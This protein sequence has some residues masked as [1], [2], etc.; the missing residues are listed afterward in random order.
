MTTI[1]I[2]PSASNHDAS[3][4]GTGAV[5]LTGHL[6]AT[7]G[8]HWL[9]LLLPGVTVPVGATI[10]SATLYYK[11]FSTT[12][13]DPGFNWYAEASDSASVF[14]TGASNVSGRSRTAAVTGDTATNIGTGS[15]RTVNITAQVDE[16]T[17]RTGW[18]SGNNIALIA[19]ATAAADIWILSYDSGSGIW[20]VEI[21]YTAGRLTRTVSASGDDG[22]ES[23]GGSM[24]L[25]TTTMDT[26]SVG[27][28]MG[29]MFRGVQVPTGSSITTAYLKVYTND[30][31]RDSP[32]VTIKAQYNPAAFGTGST[33]FSSRTMTT[34]SASWVAT[35]IGIGAYKNSPSLTSVLQEVVDNGGW[36]GAGDVAFF[37]IQNS[38]SGWLRVASWDH[39]TDPPPQ[40]YVEWSDAPSPISG[41]GDVTLGAVTG[42]AAAVLPGHG[43]AASTLGAVTTSGA[44]AL[45]THGAGA[46]TLGAVTG[47]AAG[48]L[49]IKGAAGAAVGS[50]SLDIAA[51]GDDGH[52]DA[53]GTVLL[54]ASVVIVNSFTPHAGLLFRNVNIPAG[55][56]VTAAY[57]NIVPNTYDDPNL[58]IWGEYDPASFAATSNNLSGRT[59]TTANV[60]WSAANIGLA[61]YHAS[62]DIS[63]VIQEIVDTV[64]WGS[65][66]NLALHLIDNGGGLY[67]AAD[68]SVT[69]GPPQLVVEW[70]I[71]ATGNEIDAVTGSGAAALATHGAADVTLGA[72]TGAAVGG[73]ISGAAGAAT[74]DAITGTAAATLLTHADAA[75]TL[76]AVTS[77]AAGA[78]AIVGAGSATLDAA[79]TSGAGVLPLL[80][81]ADATLGAVTSSGAAVLTIVGAGAVTLGDVTTAGQGELGLEVGA[82]AGNVTLGATTGAATA[83]LL[84]VGAGAS[85][86][87]AVTTEG[88]GALLVAAAGAATL[89]STTTSGAGRVSI[90]ASGAAALGAVTTESAALLPIGAGG[91]VATGDIVSTASGKLAIVGAAAVTLDT[92]TGAAVGLLALAGAGSATIDALTATGAGAVATHGA[93]AASLADMTGAAASL[94]STHGAGAASVTVVTSGAG[95]VAIR[96]AAAVALGA[97]TGAGA[98]VSTVVTLGAGDA[99]LAPITG[100]AASVLATH[101]EGD[102]AITIIG[103]AVGRVLMLGSGAATLDAISASGA[104]VLPIKA[105]GTAALTIERAAVAALAITG[106]GAADVTVT[107]QGVIGVTVFGAGA[108]TLGAITGEAVAHAALV[109]VF[110]GSVT[111]PGKAGR[112]LYPTPRGSVRT[113][114]NLRES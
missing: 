37:L 12:R 68:E 97:V 46:V 3:Q 29:F 1:T 75:V 7:A 84:I 87:D 53:D 30:S 45:T 91:D 102:A 65:G 88:A 5:T 31:G 49:P 39:A 52:E 72:I 58:V 43:V 92:I 61:A 86:L 70:T 104:G 95:A 107:G 4:D 26:D 56:T 82:G 63:A 113:A 108:A 48:V 18:A 22:A 98:G 105:T 103:A 94:L 62:P 57:I 109:S 20:Y 100:A 66:D 99:T 80:G 11:P 47:T 42:S 71:A 112:V 93:G 79:T 6:V 96:G 110:I 28:I 67:F 27:D 73:V 40:L 9:G 76:G 10:N 101:G 59:R 77:S 81:A 54:T 34:A 64:G 50:F 32:N 17:T 15:Y 13:D 60:A 35:D 33:N 23:T 55:A 14:T 85:T 19:D 78:L 21:D 8:T 25:T 2:N 69:Y 41:A 106:A 83:M 44:A 90:A 114:G 36:T 89:G 24:T 16:V 74:L 38:A 111:S 51:G